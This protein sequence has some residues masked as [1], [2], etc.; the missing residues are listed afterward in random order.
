M[1][2]MLNERVKSMTVLDISLVKLSAFCFAIIVVKLFPVLLSISYLV[3]IVLILAFGA[4]PL[5]KIWVKK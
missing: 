1:I 2:Q 5:Y 4:M 3:L